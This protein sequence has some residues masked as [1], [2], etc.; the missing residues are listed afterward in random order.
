MKVR[1]D[2]SQDPKRGPVFLEMESIPRGGEFLVSGTYGTCGVLKV[3]YTPDEP[4]QDV[5]L[6]LGEAQQ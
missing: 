5:V 1:L 6:V 2:F 4:T 3:L